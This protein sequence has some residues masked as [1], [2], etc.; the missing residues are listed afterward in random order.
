MSMGIKITANYIMKGIG[1]SRKH[2][3]EEETCNGDVRVVF[4][5]G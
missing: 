3:Q 2:F 4:P 1:N 5:L